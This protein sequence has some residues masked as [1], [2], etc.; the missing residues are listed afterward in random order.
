MSSTPT[1]PPLKRRDLILAWVAPAVLV[2]V[3]STQVL[4]ANMSDLT[5]WRGG[6]FGMFSTIDNHDLRLVRII[7][8]DDRGERRPLDDRE[9]FDPDSPFH[10]RAVTARALPTDST[11]RALGAALT[12]QPTIVRG[13]VASLV[14]TGNPE[15]RPTNASTLPIEAVD[16]TVYRVAFDRNRTTLELSPIIRGNIG[17]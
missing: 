2:L 10:A 1:T 12:G 9:L 13:G 16:I 7:V 17:P 5:P 3:A 8:T 15:P 4:I 6:G 14:P 11:V